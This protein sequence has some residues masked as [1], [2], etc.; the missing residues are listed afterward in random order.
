MLK[1]VKISINANGKCIDFIGGKKMSKLISSD[2][3]LSVFLSFK[4]SINQRTVDK[5]DIF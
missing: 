3:K 2:C 1:T 4:I 5:N